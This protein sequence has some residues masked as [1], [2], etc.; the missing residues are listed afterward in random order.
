[1]FHISLWR[2]KFWQGRWV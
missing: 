2:I 1:M